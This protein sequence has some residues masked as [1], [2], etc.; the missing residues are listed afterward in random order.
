MDEKTSRIATKSALTAKEAERAIVQNLPPINRYGEVLE[1][2][3]E[4]G[5]ATLIVS[6][7][8]SCCI[9]RIAPPH[10]NCFCRPAS[11]RHPATQSS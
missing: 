2:L 10:P 3:G 6:C 5:D 8:R 4:K 9:A 11:S 7:C 1:T